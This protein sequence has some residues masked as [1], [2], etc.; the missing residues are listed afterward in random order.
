[1]D[2]YLSFISL[3]P[4]PWNVKFFRTSKKV[5]STLKCKTDLLEEELKKIKCKFWGDII[6]V[7]SKKEKYL[8]L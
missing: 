6:Q 7:K 5:K 3:A 2:Q 4:I 1:M 8:L